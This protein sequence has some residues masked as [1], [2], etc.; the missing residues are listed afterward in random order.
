MMLASVEPYGF[1]VVFGLLLTGVL[2]VVIYPIIG[3]VL[4]I[5]QLLL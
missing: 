4:G 2:G 1:F 5:L 3:A